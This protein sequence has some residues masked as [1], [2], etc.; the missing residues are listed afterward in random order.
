MPG[1][2]FP[3]GENKFTLL[4]RNQ[5]F[6]KYLNMIDLLISPSRFLLEQFRARGL[7]KQKSVQV[8]NGIDTQ[9]FKNLPK[10]HSQK[11]RFCY[12]G[13]IVEHKG[14]DI[15]LHSV[16]LLSRQEREQIAVKIVGDGED[17]FVQYC[18]CLA[19]ELGINAC[20]HFAG[21]L[22]NSRIKEVLSHTD[23]LVVPSV[24][25]ENSPVV[26]LEALASGT[27]VLGSDIGGIP[28]FVENGITGFLHKHDD[29]AS[30]AYNMRRII[31]NPEIIKAM[32][33]GCLDIAMQND[34][35]GT[36]DQIAGYYEALSDRY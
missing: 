22:P 30:L 11:I 12:I 10:T 15:F 13:Q 27:P 9:V 18:K 25:F 4:E 21:K 26:I 8:K 29:P 14:P 31:E 32:R 34:L 16:A 28:E 3:K 17:A 7:L 6:L 33:P 2:F 1:E 19:H 23:V 5:L 36:I 24:W 35:C 20:V